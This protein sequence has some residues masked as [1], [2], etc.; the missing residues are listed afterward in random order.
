MASLLAA[1]Y[2]RLLTV[3]EFLQIDF[4][5]GLKAE[6]DRGVIRMMA[7]GTREHARVQANLMRFLGIALRGSGCR[8][9]GSD[10]QVRSADLSL[11]YPDVSVDC[12]TPE[13]TDADTI[14]RAPR[15]LIEILSPS[16]RAVDEG[17]KLD[18]Y[19]SIASVDT[20]ALIDPDTRWLRV[21]QRTGPQAWSDVT[22]S[23][24]APL[25]LPALGVSIPHDEIFARD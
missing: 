18:E 10:M 13:D 15:V 20:V 6:L 19:R 12:G 4:G 11:R 16:T 14:L 25:D 24:P 1:P 17:P 21:L 3:E 23:S 5:P 8:P 2:P 7:G 9:Y 22:F